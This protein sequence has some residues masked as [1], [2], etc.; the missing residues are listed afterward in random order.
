[1]L[2]KN[3]QLDQFQKLSIQKMNKKISYLEHN[4][5]NINSNNDSNITDIIKLIILMTRMAIFFTQFYLR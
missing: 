3:K 1:M 4:N 5:K 2:R